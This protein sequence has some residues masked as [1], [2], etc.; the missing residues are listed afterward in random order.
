[1]CL[2][3]KAGGDPLEI[4]EL[5][6]KIGDALA[7][8]GRGAESAGA[9]LSA[10]KEA[11]LA[12]SLDLRRR[13]S[14]QLLR[15]GRIP[16]GLQVT[17]EVLRAVGMSLAKS[18][19]RALA[20]VIAQRARLRLRGLSFKERD[21]SEI[22]ASDLTRIDV[23][24]SVGVGLA[25]VDT[26]RG[27]D[28]QTRNLRLALEAGEPYRIARAL[29]IE[30]M[31]SATPGAKGGARTK[32]LLDAANELAAKVRRPHLLGLCKLAGGATAFLEGRFDQAR[33]VCMEAE[34]VF[35]EQCTGVAW[36]LAFCQSFLHWSLY[37]VGELAELNRRV[38]L[39]VQAAEERG[40]L[41]AL[42]NLRTEFVSL[43]AMMADDIEGG[44]KSVNEAMRRW[45][46]DGF[47]IE[48]AWE[49]HSLAQI[50]LY[51]GTPDSA[52]TRVNN[53]WRALE[54][55]LTLQIQQ[56]LIEFLYLRGRSA[57]S[58]AARSGLRQDLLKI[59]RSDGERLLRTQAEWAQPLGRVLL[60]SH[61]ALIGD[62]AAAFEHLDAAS[63][64]FMERRMPMHSMASR[65]RSAQLRADPSDQDH[66]VDWFKARQVLVP[67]SWIALLVPA[68]V[69]G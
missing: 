68:V 42:T 60:G 30:A 35:R 21:A 26:I 18:P 23:C 36:E 27:S 44:R 58:A 43:V 54:R 1:M 55:S 12:E 51:A 45:T 61:A 56:L 41:Y 28:F 64:G 46:N 40:D 63:A 31:Y 7:N 13:A 3:L 62:R 5:Q 52:F 20:S 33:T 9:Y 2:Q 8:A 15:S 66:V 37:F 24:W 29:S 65:Y 53:A 10:A 57:L 19:G 14:E 22:S 48:H 17:D 39:L 4:R 38:P 6:V 47:H 11:S 16:E 25:M 50:D 49:V 59:G 67:A 34:E 69:P 32:R